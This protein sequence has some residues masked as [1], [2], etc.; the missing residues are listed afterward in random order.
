WM[1]FVRDIKAQK[2]HRGMFH[3]LTY[4]SSPKLCYV[5]KPCKLSTTVSCSPNIFQCC[6]I[7]GLII[8][9]L[10]SPS[11]PVS[12]SRKRLHLADAVMNLFRCA[13][14]WLL[15]DSVR[16]RY[17]C[18]WTIELLEIS[19]ADAIEFIDDE[20]NVYKC[21]RDCRAWVSSG[22]GS[23]QPCIGTSFLAFLFLATYLLMTTGK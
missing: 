15:Y 19:F 20:V 7:A 2:K 5:S 1:A 17:C 16:L 3:Q 9:K 11:S 21:D 23:Q 12:C 18:G 6:E 22:T 8:H 4:I 13:M 14:T 10:Q